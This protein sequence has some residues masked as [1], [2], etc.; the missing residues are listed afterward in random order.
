MQRHVRE[1]HENPK[2]YKCAYCEEKFTQ[3][4][5][6]RRHEISKHTGVYPFNC[7]KCSRGFHQKWQ[8]E[9]HEES[10]KIYPCPNCE[11]HFDKWTLFLKHCKETQHSR[12]YY[13]CEHCSRC[14]LKPSELQKHVAAKHL[15][16]TE[17]ISGGVYKC[18]HENCQKSYAYERNLRQH[19][20]T[21]HEDKKFKCSENDCEKEFSSLQNLQ[22][23]LN[24]DHKCKPAKDGNNSGS[25]KQPAL[26]RKRRKDAGK[27][28]IANLA[29][30]SG[31]AVDKD[32][33]KRLKSRDKEALEEVTEHL[34]QEIDINTDSEDNLQLKQ[35]Q[36]VENS[37]EVT[38]QCSSQLQET[39]GIL[40]SLKSKGKCS[41]QQNAVKEVT[42]QLPE[43][44]DID[45][46]SG[47]VAQDEFIADVI[48]DFE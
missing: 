42:E 7:S 43:Q 34:A 40:K 13:K 18:S 3:K 39:K 17:N 31:I 9:K 29:K 21:A 6:M 8:W 48:K 35:A 26:K 36:N 27:S 41:K 11:L 45:S 46:K 5:K 16:M 10:C 47:E 38:E 22:K 44:M 19:I 12:T 23:H 2:V 20:A 32:L 33:N 15:D 25:T 4:L 1:V 14:Y 37:N 28:K 24:R 30:L